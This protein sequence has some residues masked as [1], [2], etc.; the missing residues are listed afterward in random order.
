MVFP[1]IYCIT[2]YLFNKETI[3]KYPLARLQIVSTD[4]TR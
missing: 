3:N 2:S 1:A 4:N